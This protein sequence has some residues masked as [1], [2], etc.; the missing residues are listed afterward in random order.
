MDP[1]LYPKNPF[2]QAIISFSTLILLQE[3]NTSKTSEKLNQLEEE[4]DERVFDCWSKCSAEE[5]EL[6]TNLSSASN[7]IVEFINRYK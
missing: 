2:Y 4:L 5:T 3:L 7:S 1:I 6:L